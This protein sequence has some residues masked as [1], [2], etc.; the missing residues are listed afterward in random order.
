MRILGFVACAL[1]M[2][3]VCLAQ[4]A[5]VVFYSD[6][7]GVKNSLA[8][9]APTSRQPFPGW[10]YEGDERLAHFRAGRFLVLDFEPGMH[11]FSANRS[12]DQ[13]SPNVLALNLAADS[14]YCVR[15]SAA[16]V[17]WYPTGVQTYRGRMEAVPCGTATGAVQKMKTLD[18][19]NLL[20][21]AE[22]KLDQV[23]ELPAQKP[24]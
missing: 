9:I 8:G 2:G 18:R 6:A 21:P 11:V 23:Q 20:K 10:L 16:F 19:K 12:S 17:N 13:S 7:F 5:R 4:K 22:D 24:E 3:P 1:L 14:T 15:L